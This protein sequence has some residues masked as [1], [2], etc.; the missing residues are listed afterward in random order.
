MPG[1]SRASESRA[2]PSQTLRCPAEAG[3]R[4]VSARVHRPSLSAALL[5]KEDGMSTP[6]PPDP[7]PPGPEPAPSP[8]PVAGAAAPSR[9][10]SGADVLKSRLLG[11][12][13]DVQPDRRAPRRLAAGGM[14]RHHGACGN[15][16]A[17]RWIQA[18]F[19]DILSI[20]TRLVPTSTVHHFPKART[21]SRRVPASQAGNGAVDRRS[22][23]PI[24]R[25]RAE[26]EEQRE[27]QHRSPRRPGL[28]SRRGWVR[29]RER[30]FG[31]RISGE[32][33]GQ[34]VVQRWKLP[35]SGC[36]RAATRSSGIR[37]ARGPTP[38]GRC[39]AARPCR[40]GS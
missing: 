20:A 5:G 11:P 35:R 16:R 40:C 1:F 9:R 22:R 28:R 30:G 21:P 31:A 6:L 37:C 7:V 12:G 18:Q 38:R 27:A 3:H 34:R 4:A 24:R 2:R 36:R 26:A 32:H 29:D 15:A 33:L 23:G 8:G 19:G 39:R 13:G 17:K 14:L 25:V 10:T